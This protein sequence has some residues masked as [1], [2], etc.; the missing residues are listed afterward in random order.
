MCPYEWAVVG[1]VFD[2]LPTTCSVT[3]FTAHAYRKSAVSACCNLGHC[4]VLRPTIHSQPFCSMKCLYTAFW[5]LGFWLQW[6][7]DFSLVR[8]TTSLSN[9]MAIFSRR[10]VKGFFCVTTMV[11]AQTITAV[12]VCWHDLAFQRISLIELMPR[13]HL[14]TYCL[15]NVVCGVRD[16]FFPTQ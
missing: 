2:F 3:A 16:C 6:V 15:C 10:L 8:I 7:L 13:M 14:A 12:R 5:D 1:C 9:H 4:W 11:S